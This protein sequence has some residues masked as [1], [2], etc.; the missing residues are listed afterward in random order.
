MEKK[1]LG[2]GLSA[3]LPEQ[4]SGV[5]R[6]D[7]PVHHIP[8]SEIV[9]NRFQPRK[10]FLQEE[11]ESLA[12]SIKQNGILQPILVR[13]KGDGAYE[14]IAGERR[15]RAAQL[16]NLPT[17]PAIVRNSKDDESSILALVE[18]LQRKDLNPMEEARAYVQLIEEFGL[19]QEM[20][21]EQVGRPR[22]TV[23]NVLRLVSLPNEIQ[24]L[25]EAGELTFGHA[26]VILGFGNSKT[27]IAL[28]NKIVR[29]Q[30]S[31]RDVEKMIKHDHRLLKKVRKKGNNSPLSSPYSDV[32]EQLRK[33]FGTKVSIRP[34]NRGGELTVTFYSQEDLTRIVEVILAS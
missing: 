7:Q 15:Y 33:H 11:L 26:K 3:L 27:Q 17:I 32:E 24:Q 29:D 18:N 25:I 2:R 23:A 28:A 30:L 21:A 22:S 10:Q 12:Q 13:R 31:V 16:I 20:V 1:A 6:A 34:K 8:L 5:G 9:P 4:D 19:T 14:L